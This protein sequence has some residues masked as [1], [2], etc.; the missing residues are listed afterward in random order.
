MISWG[1][2]GTRGD[3]GASPP[4]ACMLKKAPIKPKAFSTLCLT[5]KAKVDFST[6]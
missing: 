6:L 1:G 4:P 5:Y 3:W 2:G